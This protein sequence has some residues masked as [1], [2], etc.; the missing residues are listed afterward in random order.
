MLARMEHGTKHTTNRATNYTGIA[1]PTARHQNGLM[2]Q[3]AQ[4]SLNRLAG[5]YRDWRHDRDITAIARVLERLNDRQLAM[6]GL[7]RAMLEVDVARLAIRAGYMEDT[8]YTMVEE[9]EPSARADNRN[10]QGIS[11]F[12]A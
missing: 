9:A 2:R 7:S 5:M 11:L 3:L 12:H 4:E 8:T 6:L 10:D 1:T